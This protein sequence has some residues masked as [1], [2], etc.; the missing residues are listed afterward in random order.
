MATILPFVSN[1]IDFDDEATRI[2]GEA[3][4]RHGFPRGPS[5]VPTGQL[6]LVD[7]EIIAKRIIEAGKEEERARSGSLA[8]CWTS[9]FGIRP[10][11][12]L[13][14]G[15]SCAADHKSRQKNGSFPPARNLGFPGP[16][17][18]FKIPS[19]P[20]ALAMTSQGVVMSKISG[21]AALCQ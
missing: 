7:C 21:G 11:S 12:D 17:P 19:K 6:A 3:F 18:T 10:G 14:A 4:G 1:K 8:R 2:M 20:S 15:R 9:R 5:V 16:P 13:G